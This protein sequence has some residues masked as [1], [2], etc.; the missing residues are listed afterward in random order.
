MIIHKEYALRRFC[1][2]PLKHKLC[3]ELLE[4]IWADPVLLE[5]LVFVTTRE[6]LENTMVVSQAGAEEKSFVLRLQRTEEI[7][8][9]DPLEAWFFLQ[10]LT[11]LLHVQL[12]FQNETPSW[13]KELAVPNEAVVPQPLATGFSA[14]VREQVELIL[15]GIT[16]KEQI[17]EALRTRDEELFRETVELYKEVCQSCFWKL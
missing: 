2:V 12:V 1:E 15:W 5:R 13:Y 11:H 9:E 17:D 8:I 7:L 6:C 3:Q 4:R 14:F 10:D 16:L